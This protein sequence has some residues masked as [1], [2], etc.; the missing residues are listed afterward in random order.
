MIDAT[1]IT[2]RVDQPLGVGS[3]PQMLSYTIAREQALDLMVGRRPPDFDGWAVREWQMR[4]ERAE[5]LA[6]LIAADLAHTML[7]A[8][9]DDRTT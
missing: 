5:K 1:T 8:F 2:I 6:Q 4:M 3:E 9:N 7:R